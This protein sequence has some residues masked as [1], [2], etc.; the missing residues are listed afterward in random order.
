MID[1]ADIPDPMWLFPFADYR[2]TSIPVGAK[3]QLNNV[4]RVLGRSIES[5]L[6]L[7]H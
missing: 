7:G 2:H 3:H 5:A 4:I 6:S 1:L